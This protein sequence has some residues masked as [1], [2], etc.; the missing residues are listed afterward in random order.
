[1]NCSLFM[2]F[3]PNNGF[4]YLLTTTTTAYFSS[5]FNSIAILY[6]VDN[7]VSL[8]VDNLTA[9]FAS[10]ALFKGAKTGKNWRQVVNNQTN[11]VIVAIQY[12]NTV[13]YSGKYAVV[14]SC[15][16]V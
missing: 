14:V 2:C 8:I 11:V 1:M 5:I 4:F 10:S 13:E 12:G 9:F 3:L 7:N 15:S 16:I 6:D